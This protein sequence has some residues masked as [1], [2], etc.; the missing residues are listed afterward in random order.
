MENALSAIRL[1]MPFFH[2]IT[3]AGLI[4]KIFLMLGFR[5]F[6]LPYLVASYFRFYERSDLQMAEGK[7]RR[8]Y[9][10]S[11]NIINYYTYTYIFLCLICLL[12]FGSL[13]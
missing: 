2:I 13:V 5:N 10:K 6:D 7:Q 8:A 4:I 9:V 12:A 1:L 11:N 3:A